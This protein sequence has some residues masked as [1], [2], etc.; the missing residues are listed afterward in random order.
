MDE[1]LN[2]LIQLPEGFPYPD[3]LEIAKKLQCANVFV[4]GYIPP[5]IGLYH[6][7]GFLYGSSVEGVNTVLLPDRNIVSRIAQVAKGEVINDERRVAAAVLAFSQCL[8]IQ[9]EPSIAFHELAP[10]QGNEAAHEE[11]RLFHAAD[12]SDPDLW[13]AVSLGRLNCIPSLAVSEVDMVDLASPLRRWRMNYIVVLKI[14]ELELVKMSPIDRVMALL[15]WM[16]EDF[17]LAGPGILFACIYFA[18]NSPPRA[19]LLKSLRSPQRSR[20]IHGAQNAAW[21]LTHLSD[22]L[23]RAN[24]SLEEKTHYIFATFDEG[25]RCIA[26][27]LF[28]N[29]R[30]EGQPESLVTGLERWWPSKDA[31]RIA[32]AIFKGYSAARKP[33]WHDAQE[34]QRPNYINDL[35][36]EGE[37]HLNTW[38]GK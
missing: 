26:E 37:N 8:D 6:P 24:T 35:M 9:I 21:D 20:A 12:N 14:A 31:N 34:Q 2:I 23:R 11:L 27:L 18:P 33:E 3:L 38:S 1:D 28:L 7:D 25:L 32:D 30:E 17:I 36:F 22:F 19:G 16:Y 5:S 15:K 10:Y 4:P 13:I 29:A